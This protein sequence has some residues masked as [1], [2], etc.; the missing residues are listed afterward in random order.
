MD[1][2]LNVYIVERL[3][4]WDYDDCIEQTLIA[5]NDERAL[6]LARKEVGVWGI[7]RIVDLTKEQVLTQN[8]HGSY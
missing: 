4:G 6:E 1:K 5:E 8:Y 2:I 3:D 7:K